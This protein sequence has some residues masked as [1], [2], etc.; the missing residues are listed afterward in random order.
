MSHG[1]M[2]L[3]ERKSGRDVGPWRQ[4]SSRVT[5]L[6]HARKANEQTVVEDLTAIRFTISRYTYTPPY[7]LAAAEELSRPHMRG[8]GSH[9]DKST[10]SQTCD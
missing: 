8:V 6:M 4:S 3:R 9:V 10:K 1:E 2:E 7:Y 5:S